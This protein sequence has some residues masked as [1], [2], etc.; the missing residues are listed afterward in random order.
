MTLDEVISELFKRWEDHLLDKPKNSPSHNLS[1][2]D[3]KGFQFS[4]SPY[5]APIR[6]E[7]FGKFIVNST[8]KDALISQLKQIH[9]LYSGVNKIYED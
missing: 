6:V 3:F 7:K 1:K 4:I 9:E 2:I 8:S 5:Y